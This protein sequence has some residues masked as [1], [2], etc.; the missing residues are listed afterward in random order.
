MVLMINHD[1]TNYHFNHILDTIMIDG[2]NG[3]IV[4]LYFGYD[5]IWLIIM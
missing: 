2:Y 1:D 4:I 3:F 5:R